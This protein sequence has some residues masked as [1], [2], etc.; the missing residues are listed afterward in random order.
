MI[1]I[2]VLQNMLQGADRRECGTRKAA[3]RCLQGKH[4]EKIGDQRKTPGAG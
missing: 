1:E 3:G 4:S 2:L